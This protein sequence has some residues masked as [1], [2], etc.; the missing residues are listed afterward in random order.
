M[1]YDFILAA[2]EGE[3]SNRIWEEIQTQ[4]VC[5]TE[6]AEGRRT[7]RRSSIAR[8]CVRGGGWQEG[9]IEE[10]QRTEQELYTPTT[11]RVGRSLLLKPCWPG[12]AWEPEIDDC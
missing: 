6:Q 2:V 9:P 7:T 10:H 12:T 5:I 11:Q 4:S 3:L 1:S 8:H